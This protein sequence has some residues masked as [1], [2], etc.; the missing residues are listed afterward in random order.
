MVCGRKFTSD[1]ISTHENICARRQ[2]NAKLTGMKGPGDK[3][4]ESKGGL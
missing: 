3:E 2:N 4:E 1:R